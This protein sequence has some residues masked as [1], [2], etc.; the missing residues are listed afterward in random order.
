MKSSKVIRLSSLL[1][2]LTGVSA[3]Q[4]DNE[5]FTPFPETVT[6][7]VPKNVPADF[8][9]PE[10]DTT[11]NNRVT[12]YIK[13]KVNIE[14]AYPF[15]AT[16]AEQYEQRINLMVASGDIPDALSVD[17]QLF[18]ELAEGG[19]LED[20]SP[21]Y[22]DNA[23]P[24]LKTIHEQTEGVALERATVDGQLL[25]IP[26]VTKDG[27]AVNFM[28]IRQ[29][30]LENLGLEAPQT[31][32]ELHEVARAFTEGDPDGNGQD[33]T[34]GIGGTSEWQSSFS[35]IFAAQ[36]AFPGNWVESSAGEVVYG[37]VAPEMKEALT[38]LQSWYG[39]GLIDPEFATLDTDGLV[40]KVSSGRVGIVFGPWW[41][42]DW[43]LKFTLENNA[44]ADWT[45]YLTPLSADGKFN[46]FYGS[47]TG[48]FFVVR[49]G[50]EHPEAAFKVVNL[51]AEYEAPSADLDINY[52][53]YSDQPELNVLWAAVWPTG[54]GFTRLDWLPF[55]ALNVQNALDTGKTDGLAPNESKIL[56]TVERLGS[57]ELT[58]ADWGFATAWA[59]GVPLLADERIVPHR[60][61]YQADT[62]VA[63]NR[64]WPT[65]E[66][67]EDETMLRILTGQLPIEAFDTF[68]EE[69]NRLGGTEILTTVQEAVAE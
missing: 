54:T 32:E 10:G 45:P 6:L 13:D 28:W 46:A 2:V 26:S 18:A 58:P 15:V 30:W 22:D 66:K 36:G 4:A 21:Y 55:H 44:E 1:I 48:T 61:I 39:E 19:L 37:T 8:R 24:L 40:Q 68:S 59:E 64:I 27:D 56:D 34:Q 69:W 14:M 53:S 50:Y 57:A 20:L 9:L 51:Q 3:Q 62:V 11:D 23:S 67:R 63:D 35:P 52:L 29:D 42:S 49:K 31:L 12:R 7:A 17:A 43:P 47:N 60:E 5:A 41:Y 16:T 38:T 25:G 65:L 33:D